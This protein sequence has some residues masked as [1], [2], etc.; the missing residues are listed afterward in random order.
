MTRVSRPRDART[1]SERLLVDLRCTSAFKPTATYA[2]TASRSSSRPSLL[3]ASTPGVQ[4]LAEAQ[5]QRGPVAD[6]DRQATATDRP[7]DGLRLLRASRADEHHRIHPS[8]PVVTLGAD[9]ELTAQPPYESGS[10]G[11]RIR[12]CEGRANAFT[13]RPV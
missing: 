11:G 3:P 8:Q 6:I 10:G 9:D 13:A 12:T 4:L 1:R 7:A 5:L 2:A